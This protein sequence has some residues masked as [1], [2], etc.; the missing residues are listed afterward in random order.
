VACIVVEVRLRRQNARMLW[1]GIYRFLSRLIGLLAG[2]GGADGERDLEIA[3]LCHQIAV[4][5]RQGKRP[6]YRT[7]DRA[8]LA[9]AA[10]LLPRERWSC[11]LVRPE[12]LL[13]WDR[14][15]RCRA[16]TRPLRKPGRPP[17]DREIRYLVIRLGREK[18]RWGYMRIRGELLKLGIGVSAT[19]I[20]TLLRRAGL[21][22]APRR[23]GPTW[24]EF[25]RAQAF[26]L[27]ARDHRPDRVDEVFDV[28]GAPTEA[29]P[30]EDG[31]PRVAAGHADGAIDEAHDLT[32]AAAPLGARTGPSVGP[33]VLLTL[34]RS[35][36]KHPL[37]LATGA[38]PPP[39]RR[40]E[41]G[42]P[43]RHAPRRR[44][45]SWPQQRCL[46]SF[47]SP[48][49]WIEFHVDQRAFVLR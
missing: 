8:L 15:F 22:P 40:L 35:M 3:V 18:P 33:G 21:G 6:R 20:A 27:L 45:F 49:E 36:P 14:Q 32:Q 38:R 31:P 39:R 34:A 11:F 48:R 37:L 28:V 2:V 4:I 46:C 41:P 12:T 29:V 5:S 43:T 24:S 1:A 9:A 16:P 47:V 10:R 25:L 26:G 42:A 44:F 17:I 30:H 23:I 7:A 13:R 19:T